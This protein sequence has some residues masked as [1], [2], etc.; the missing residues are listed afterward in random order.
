MIEELYTV[1]GL[2]KELAFFISCGNNGIFSTTNK[3][4]LEI[5]IHM[6]IEEAKRIEKENLVVNIVSCARCGKNHDNLSF[7][8]MRNPSGK[9]TH[10][11]MCPNLNEPILLQIF[12]LETVSMEEIQ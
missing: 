11:T 4:W 1:K 7:S 3:K 2:E 6:A 8:K 5:V 12:N 9:N 10:W